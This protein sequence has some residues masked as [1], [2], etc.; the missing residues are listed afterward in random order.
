MTTKDWYTLSNI[1]L[2]ES[3][4]NLALY[5]MAKNYVALFKK[6]PDTFAECSFISTRNLVNRKINK[7][8]FLYLKPGATHIVPCII[9]IYSVMM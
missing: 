4:N 8:I 1:L 5:T 6:Y 2:K 9:I 7:L 3:V